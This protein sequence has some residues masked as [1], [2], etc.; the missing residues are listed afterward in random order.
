MKTF[1]VSNSFHLVMR[2]V[3]VKSFKENQNT[4]YGFYNFLLVIFIYLFYIYIYIYINHAIY[5][6]MWRNIVERNS[7]Q[8]TIWHMRI[9][10]CIHTSADTYLKYLLIIAFHCSNSWTNALQC[11]VIRTLPLSL[12]TIMVP[13]KWTKVH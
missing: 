6:I 12:Y 1:M 7:S 2:N 10:C 4:F 13:T 8:M 11:Y 3:S 5:E 9:T